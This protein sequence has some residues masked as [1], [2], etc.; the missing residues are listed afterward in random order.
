MDTNN[1]YIPVQQLI[2][3][4]QGRLTREQTQELDY[5]LLQNDEAFEVLMFLEELRDKGVLEEY[6][7]KMDKKF[8]EKLEAY[9]EHSEKHSTEKKMVPMYLK[10]SVAASVTLLLAIGTYSLLNTPE[11]SLYTKYYEPYYVP[12]ASRNTNE[13]EQTD[14]Q[15]R[16]QAFYA[17]RQENFAKAIESLELLA[18]QE[19]LTPQEHLVLVNAYLAIQNLEQAQDTLA[20]VL[21]QQADKAAY[22]HACWYQALIYIKQGKP[23]EAKPFLEKAVQSPNYQTKAADLLIELSTQE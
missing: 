20:V 21:A 6:L 15:L 7:E 22:Y 9:R 19:A 17:Y 3:Y 16:N 1:D 14:E 12:L 13:A 8:F 11:D 5:K 2:A 4:V 18:A 10:L 23:A